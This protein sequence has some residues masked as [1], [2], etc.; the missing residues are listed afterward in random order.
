MEHIIIASLI[1]AII[2]H[3]RINTL[4]KE[5]KTLKHTLEQLLNKQSSVK[6]SPTSN[7]TSQHNVVLPQHTNSQTQHV[8]DKEQKNVEN[9]LGKNVIGVIAAVLM[10]I[11]IF[12]FG[13]LVLQSFSD[14]FKVAGM[15]IFSCLVVV[16]GL[17][18]HHKKQS[19]F[20]E[21]V[22]GCGFGMIYIS[23]FLTHLYY[24]MIS[25]I[26]TFILIFIWIAIISILSKKHSMPILSYI[27][28]TGC[29]VSSILA[30]VYVIQNNMFT[31]IVIYHFLTFLLLI[32]TNKD[33]CL[34]F[35]ISA[36]C[37]ITLNIVLSIVIAIFN[38]QSLSLCFVL[39]IYNII[40][41]ILI[42]RDERG[43]KTTSIIIS[44]LSYAANMVFTGIIPLS[45]LLTN[46]LQGLD[47]IQT[48]LPV[49]NTNFYM[50]KS[51]FFCIGASL[52]AII[53]YA[54][55]YLFIKDSEKRDWILVSTEIVWSLTMLLD[56]L[57]LA[58]KDISLLV[59]LPIAHLL[60]CY[61]D[62]NNKQILYWSGFA[63]LIADAF[64]SL[65]FI[66]DLG[67]LSV[68]HSVMLVVLSFLYMHKQYGNAMAFPF[69]QYALVDGHLLFVLLHL[70]ENWTVVL[71]IVMI[72]H[73]WLSA[74]SESYSNSTVSAVLV[75]CVE[76]LL[77]F[78]VF[79]FIACTEEFFLERFILSIVLIPFSLM[80]LQRV[81][82]SKNAFMSVWYGL[83]F[84]F[85]TFGIIHIFTPLSEQQFV[86]SVI[87]MVLASICILFGFWKKLKAMRI[88]GL[89]LVLSSVIK[90]VIIDVWNQESIVRVLSL[91]GGAL[92]CF[93]ISAAY[94]HFETHQHKK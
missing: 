80:H 88:Y 54:A 17:I 25:D 59:I 77:A 90:M 20:S 67:W 70:F 30:Q 82:K 5:N 52:I 78:I 48:L 84:T 8:V 66:A 38:H 58:G 33:N 35:K 83:K 19:M 28:L 16:T 3:I 68:V 61:F 37:S 71:I 9:V 47:D 31:E 11:G 92:I 18:L 23:I 29:I 73:S 49:D 36:Y 1:L 74:F 72:L 42:C 15:F 24:N 21:I 81:V 50:Q 93:G 45:I 22:T 53:S 44:C 86:V 13:T 87:L 32:F 26:L 14:G 12:A 46:M 91:I 51:I 76:S 43:D 55:Y 69:F 2:A 85:Y 7:L 57:E 39:G 40:I 79:W 89:V 4:S 62:K 34:L 56:P 63:F 10:F 60:I 94:T 65:F 75:E 6:T 27:A 41:G 64:T